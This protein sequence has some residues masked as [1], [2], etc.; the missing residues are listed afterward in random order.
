MFLVLLSTIK[1]LQIVVK[2][3]VVIVRVKTQNG[4]NPISIDFGIRITAMRAKSKH[5]YMTK[6]QVKDATS[7]VFYCILDAQD[8]A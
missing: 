8:M 5:F 1:P 3:A 6:T 2:S 4:S 7:R